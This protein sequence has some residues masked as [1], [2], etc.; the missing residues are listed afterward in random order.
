MLNPCVSLQIH[1]IASR[2][3]ARA[4]VVVGRSRR[5]APST[6]V[7][8]GF[9][10][11]R[12][13]ARVR[14]AAALPSPTRRP[15]LTARHAGAQALGHAAL[16]QVRELVQKHQHLAR[17]SDAETSVGGLR[18]GGHDDA[19]AA[20]LRHLAQLVKRILVGVVVP[21][22]QRH[23][24]PFRVSVPRVQVQLPEEI[25]ERF[26]LVPRHPGFHLEN[27]ATLGFFKP[28]RIGGDG[29]M[30]HVLHR[31]PPLLLAVAVVHGHAELVVLHVGAR[32]VV[33]RLFTPPVHAIHH[34]GSPRR[35]LVELDVIVVVVALGT[36]D[37]QPVGPG[38]VELRQADKVVHLLAGPAADD[39]GG[40]QR[41]HA[42]HRVA[43]LI[44]HVRLVGVG[45]DV[46][47][48]AVVVEEDGEELALSGS[49]EAIEG[50][51][52]AGM[53]RLPVLVVLPVLFRRPGAGQL[54]MLLL[55]LRRQRAA[56]ERHRDSARGRVRL[57][58]MRAG[59]R[60]SRARRARGAAPLGRVAARDLLEVELLSAARRLLTSRRTAAQPPGG[61]RFLPAQRKSPLAASRASPQPLVVR[62]PPRL[63]LSPPRRARSLAGNFTSRR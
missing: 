59:P 47:Y 56:G 46:G 6:P 62:V 43:H 36:D 17:I 48:G 24:L 21:K 35:G 52:R 54:G 9:G 18:D 10:A 50:L 41:R 25:T 16:R 29:A 14:T 53:V 44:R 13:A 57:F 2:N 34:R 45:D 11:A 3:V 27:L 20:L 49:P 39:R 63:A 8:L 12:V 26:S 7:G 32:D 58:R 37:V 51:D 23:D 19:G 4:P 42:A 60:P 30:H 40:I 33:H 61:G 55:A 22:V 1:P 5:L 15:P 31:A 38:V 28:L